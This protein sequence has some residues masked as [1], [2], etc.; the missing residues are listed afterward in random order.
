MP[1]YLNY[2]SSDYITI[3]IFGFLFFIFGY[4]SV[5]SVYL[6]SFKE[7]KQGQASVYE[8]F[9]KAFVLQVLSTVFI[10]VIIGGLDFQAKLS[11]TINVGFSEATVSFFM[12]EWTEVDIVRL[13]K[14]YDGE[15]K[16]LE[17]LGP[18]VI[19]KAI[20]IV[21][22]V[23]IVFFPIAVTISFLASVFSKHKEGAKSGGSV[24]HLI[25]DA[26][27]T[28]VVV[29]LVFS[30]HLAIP[31]AFLQGISI[32]VKEDI[33]KKA[34]SAPLIGLSYKDRA[35][36][37]AIN[38]LAALSKSIKNTIDDTTYNKKIDWNFGA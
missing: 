29:M 11:N 24:G 34:G 13:V 9:I 7:I 36:S 1:N 18:L 31:F 27:G 38:S 32:S 4:L 26:I 35:S 19:L 30:L 17:A 37:M 16:S 14:Y 22:T 25:S 5:V 15:G 10:W 23:I 20:W 28:T 2:V 21:L 12:I 3:L 6:K 33:I 8:V